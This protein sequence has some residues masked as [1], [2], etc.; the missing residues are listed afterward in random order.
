MIE[1]ILINPLDLAIDL[2]VFV[3]GVTGISF[4]GGLYLRNRKLRESSEKTK[5]E[6][7]RR[8]Y[9]LSMLKELGERAGYSLDVENVADVIISSLHH[10]IPYATVSYLLLRSDRPIFKTYVE[11]PVSQQFVDEIKKRMQDSVNALLGKDIFLKDAEEVISGE[12]LLYDAENKIRS[13]FNIPIVVGEE[14]VGVLTVAH[15]EE[16]LY[17]EEEMTILYRIIGQA[18]R[19]LTRLKEVV[20]AEERKLNAMVQSMV[21]GVIMTDK[22]YRVIVANPA[23]KKMLNAEEKDTLNIFDLID[24]LGREVAIRGKLEE[25]IKMDKIIVEDDVLVKSKFYKIFIAP[26]KDTEAKNSGEILGGVV[27]FHDITGEKEL[28]KLREDFTSMVVH[29]LRTPLGNIQKTTDLI[30]R[31]DHDKPIKEYE[32][33]LGMMSESTQEMLRWVGDLLDA[34]KIEAGKFQVIK[35]KN[36]LKKVSERCLRF[37]EVSAKS[38]KVKLTTH[39]AKELPEEIVFDEKRVCQVLNDLVGNALKF[40]EA[41]GEISVCVFLH[42]KKQPSKQEVLKGGIPCFIEGDEEAIRNLSD[43]VVI[44]VND[45]GRGI[46]EEDIPLLFNRYQQIKERMTDKDKQGTGLGLVISKGIVEAHG[47]IIGVQSKVGEGSTFYFT[48][49][50]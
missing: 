6:M 50:I 4:A 24:E 23:A 15:H 30:L 41:G 2:I 39:F 10:L 36:N 7:N 26:V 28:E 37:I 21:E 20:V 13:F 18:G 40:T 16:G 14:V 34:A 33:Y 1:F 25:S 44:T 48:I 35:Q 17:E 29:E 32:E 46:A 27:I 45:T 43:S 38:E 9:E 19:A 42:L 31:E 47:G 11:Q 49:P 3:V 8:F 12:L 5:A 22:D